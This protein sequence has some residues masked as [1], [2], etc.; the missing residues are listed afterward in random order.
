MSLM[1]SLTAGVSGMRGF[2]TK[3]DVIG[4]NIANVNTAGF[5]ASQVNFAELVSQSLTK[6]DARFGS[7]P[8]RASGLV[9]L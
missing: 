8:K 1:R 9:K 5:K 2:Q 3:M 6:P 4:N 7:A